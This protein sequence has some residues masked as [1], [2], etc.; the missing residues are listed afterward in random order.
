MIV[1]GGVM[2]VSLGRCFGRCNPRADI[3][4]ALMATVY[5][6]GSAITLTATG[7]WGGCGPLEG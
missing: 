3:G 7:N 6:F 2:Q 4:L 1:W 5:G